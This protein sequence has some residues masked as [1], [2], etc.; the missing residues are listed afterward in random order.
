[1]LFIALALTVHFTGG[2][3]AGSYSVRTSLT[4]E[5]SAE[6]LPDLVDINTADE[7]ALEQLPGI[8]PALAERIVQ[9]RAANGPFASVD[10]LTRVPG[11]GEKTLESLRPYVTAG[12]EEAESEDTGS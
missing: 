1:M 5:R 7:E 8:G 4:A 10:D 12:G 11:I 9:D 2:V 3:T 6:E